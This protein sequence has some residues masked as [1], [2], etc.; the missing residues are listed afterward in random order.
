MIGKGGVLILVIKIF[1]IFLIIIANLTSNS[2]AQGPGFLTRAPD[3]VSQG[4]SEIVPD[5]SLP[6]TKDS[7]SSKRSESYTY[8][9]NN[10][11]IFLIYKKFE[12][13]DIECVLG[14]EINVTGRIICT[15]E[16]KL[17]NVFL[18]E[19]AGPGCIIIEDTPKYKIVKD[20]INES[21]NV[22]NTSKWHNFTKAG[23]QSISA[24]IISIYPGSWIIY[25]YKLELKNIGWSN[26]D[27]IIKYRDYKKKSIIP[28]YAYSLNS[29]YVKKEKNPY[30]IHLEKDKKIVLPYENITLTYT[31]KYEGI[32]KDAF[33][34]RIDYDRNNNNELNCNK[35]NKPEIKSISY[36]NPA[37]YELTINY[38]TPNAYDAPKLKIDD[39]S[40]DINSGDLEIDVQSWEKKYSEYVY[41]S[42]QILGLVFAFALGYREFKNLELEISRV[43]REITVLRQVAEN[44]NKYLN[45]TSYKYKN[46]EEESTLRKN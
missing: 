1:L 14:D 20:P 2:I 10:Q 27:T 6:V 7:S 15:P 40:Y 23:P 18:K 33:N 41:W 19:E 25:T 46:N 35:I 45:N 36:E 21:I 32:D 3:I 30:S 4:T 22:L 9:T 16:V 12:N 39:Q 44:Y 42:L 17:D 43:R 26:I 24:R 38:S 29:I 11:T 37:K 34:I 13:K 31:I 28:D 8:Y 5:I